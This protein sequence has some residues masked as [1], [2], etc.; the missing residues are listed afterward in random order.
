[1]SSCLKDKRKGASRDTRAK[2]G[3][4]FARPAR[5]KRSMAPARPASVE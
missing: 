3:A 1:M 4:L 5:S 2:D